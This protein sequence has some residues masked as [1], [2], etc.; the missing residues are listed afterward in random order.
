MVDPNHEYAASLDDPLVNNGV[1]LAPAGAHA[2]LNVT[3]VKNAK[4]KKAAIAISL[5]AVTISGRKV[6][7]SAEY[8]ESK[9]G[10]KAK[11]AVKGVAIGGAMGAWFGSIGGW[12]GAGIGAATGAAAGAAVAVLTGDGT[13]V[14]IPSE[15]RFTYKLSE[16]VVVN[17]QPTV[18]SCPSADAALPPIPP[19]P[20]PA[21]GELAPIPPPPAPT[22]EPAPPPQSSAVSPQPQCQPAQKAPVTSVSEPELIGVVYFRD[23]SGKL[24]SLERTAGEPRTR[25]VGLTI[26]ASSEIPGVT[27][28]VRL[29]NGQKPLFV[30]RLANGIDPATIKLLP[31]DST[32]KGRQPR[33]VPGNPTRSIAILLNVT[34]VGE[35]TY[36]LTPVKDLP[37]GEYCFHPQN[38]TG[39]YCFG[40]DTGWADSK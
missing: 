18:D 8:I 21:D 27:S 32:K 39:V 20:P 14:V 33:P 37:P 12:F 15:T 17:R 16:P 38:S 35:S 2:F 11:G 19:P 31:L 40:V 29:K 10:T 30:V 28:P 34:K 6:K 24:I 36:G 23:E 22:D 26:V 5:T 7:V 4:V 1:T 13:S 25:R 3:S 9:G